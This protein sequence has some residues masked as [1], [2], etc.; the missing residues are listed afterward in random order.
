MSFNI[1]DKE[2]EEHL[3]II[4]D[5]FNNKS[6]SNAF[7]N[8]IFSI[9]GMNPELKP[10]RKVIKEQKDFNLFLE[11]LCEL[12]YLR[13]IKTSTWL[14]DLIS[15]DLTYIGKN[16]FSLKDDY[17]K[18]QGLTNSGTTYNIN[19]INANG[20]NLVIGE[21]NSSILKIEKSISQIE[22]GIKQNGGNDKQELLALL[23][24]AE[25]LLEDIK[26]TRFIPKNEDFL[27]RLNKYSEK[28]SWFYEQ[29]AGLI[30]TAALT[31]L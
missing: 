30:G 6:S 15:Y 13:R 22:L 11:H 27:V 1:L 29:I 2:A 4:L 17:L 3:K 21:V 18:N 19:S 14:L 9:L 28:H 7:K 31:M 12:G 8:S 10:L 26:L 25:K 24:E 16:Y 23:V 5:G 20:S